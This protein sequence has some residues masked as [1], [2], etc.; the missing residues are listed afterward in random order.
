MAKKMIAASGAEVRAYFAENPKA[1]PEGAKFKADGRGRLSVAV[2]EAFTKATGKTY[3]VG[4]RDE[5][6]VS[7]VLPKEVTGKSR[8]GKVEVSVSRARALAGEAAGERGILSAEA[9]KA[10]GIALAKESLATPKS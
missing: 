9:V 4:H 6:S 5:N 7:L 8:N 2:Q 3:V 1:L 10:A